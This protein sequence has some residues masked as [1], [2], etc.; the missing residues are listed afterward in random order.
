MK[1]HEIISKLQKRKLELET[2]QK[3]MEIKKVIRHET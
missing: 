1:R 3:I 2:K